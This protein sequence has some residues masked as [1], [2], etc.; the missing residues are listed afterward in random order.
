MLR[1]KKPQV[2]SGSLQKGRWRELR[3]GA[4]V[5]GEADEASPKLATGAQRR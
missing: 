1:Q 4:D 5:S 2:E 3:K